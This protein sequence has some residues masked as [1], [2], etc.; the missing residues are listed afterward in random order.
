MIS[1]LEWLYNELGLRSLVSS[2]RDAKILCLQRFVRML[3]YGGSALILGLHLSALGISEDL[4][5][6]FLTLTLIG[7]VFIS[8]LLTTVADALGRKKI[9]LLGAT[10]MAIAGVIFSIFENYWVLLVAAVVGVISPR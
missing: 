1:P 8:F 4:I 2:T 10:L 3:A 6:L 9:L 7:D 5:G